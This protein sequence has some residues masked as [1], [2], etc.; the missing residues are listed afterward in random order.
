[1]RTYKRA[2]VAGGSYFFTVNLLD[3]NSNLLVDQI[4]A[5][6]SSFKAAQQRHPFTLEAIVILPDHLHCLMRLPP[7]DD[8][9]PV[10]WQQIKAGFSRCIKRNESISKS[11]VRKGE[12][13]IW[14][15]RYWEHVIRY[16]KDFQNHFNY[17][18]WNPVKHGL[19][20][21]VRDWP[22]SSFHR[23]VQRGVYPVDW[24]E[25]SKDV[26]DCDLG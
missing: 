26:I 2:R 11:R 18:H 20:N 3:R 15:R 13:G 21:R 14:Q 1:M 25:D 9:Y 6:R 8:C 5:L 12:R 10:R 7:G 23:W 4:E 16:E 19:V 24:I 17:I 22:H